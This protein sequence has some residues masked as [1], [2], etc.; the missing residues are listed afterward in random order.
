M[1]PQRYLFGTR[2]VRNGSVIVKSPLTVKMV[3]G[4]SF[5]AVKPTAGNRSS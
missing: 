2:K 4:P 5:Y 3:M 1:H